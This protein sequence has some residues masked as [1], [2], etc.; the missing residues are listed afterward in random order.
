MQKQH[1]ITFASL[2]SFCFIVLTGQ[3]THANEALAPSAWYSVMWNQDTDTLHWLNNAGEQASIARPQLP[4]ETGEDI[5]LA[6][7]PDG[8]NLMLH[9]LLNN[10][11]MGLG[12]YDLETGT[13]TQIHETQPGERIVPVTKTSFTLNSALSAV[14]FV[15][16]QN[17]R[18]I[19]FEVATGNALYQLHTQSPNVP[20]NFAPADTEPRIALF[21][22]DQGLAQ[23]RVHVR[24]APVQDGGMSL[25]S[26]TWTPALDTVALNT[27][28]N[29]MGDFD[30]LAQQGRFLFTT[31]TGGIDTTALQA[32]MLGD[33]A[34]ATNLYAEFEA[35]VSQPTWVANGLMVAFRV[36]QQP[37]ATMWHIMPALGGESTPF[38][39]EFD[40]L[41]GTV[42]G[43]IMMNSTTGLVKYSNTLQFEAF[44]P[45]VGNTIYSSN[46]LLSQPLQLVYVTPTGAQFTLA[47][48]ADGSPV[49]PIVA[50]DVNANNGVEPSPMPPNNVQP[51]QPVEPTSTPMPLQVAPMVPTATP[52]L[53]I[54]VVTEEPIVQ[55]TPMGFAPT[56]TPALIVQFNCPNSP[57]S[58]LQVGMTATT[59]T[60]GTL[61]MRTNLSD[62][63][64][65]HQVPNMQSVSIIAGPQC[66]EGI[67]MW[68]VSTN[69][70][71]NNV[72]G[73][74][75]EGFG[76]AYY[77]QPN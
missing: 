20:A 30:V 47:S 23:W 18:V 15:N 32:G 50:E 77:L 70:N 28:P 65:S 3:I 37:F 14:G 27:M 12:F 43:F 64:P 41:V 40:Q 11:R 61:A 34:N 44:T 69:L 74:I 42:D 54:A 6:I 68:Q 75:A 8:R 22:F 36:Q 73:W 29:G 21:D 53:Q 17:W 60:N 66:R 4:N 52:E 10:D 9:A 35:F 71:G 76:Q 58:Q 38:A 45:E 1:F 2:L 49:N 39:P 31:P 19:V 46:V 24:F 26:L 62:P 33:F 7:S 57:A 25:Q 55:I 59:S 72:I 16:G 5:G 13:F 67:R 51:V 56:S 48:L 63:Y